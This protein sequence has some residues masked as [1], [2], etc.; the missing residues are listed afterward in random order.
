MIFRWVFIPWLQ[1]ELDSYQDRI[2]HTAKRRDRNKVLPHGVPELIY[3]SAEDFG[4]LDFKIKVEKAAV[5]HVRAMY[6]KPGHLLR[7]RIV[8]NNDNSTELRSLRFV[9]SRKGDSS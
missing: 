2:N 9:V 4:A 7:T 6:I 1:R 3:R 5:D 8:L